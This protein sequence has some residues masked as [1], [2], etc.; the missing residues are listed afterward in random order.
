MQMPLSC[1]AVL[2]AEKQQVL[3]VCW[4]PGNRD[5]CC[6]MR[7]KGQHHSFRDKIVTWLLMQMLLS[8]NLVL[9]AEKQQVL[10]V[11]WVAGDRRCCCKL[12]VK[13]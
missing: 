2:G 4:I 13:G 5:Y 7:V 1:I 3:S 10:S 8:Y 11:F 9:G 12:R 6:N